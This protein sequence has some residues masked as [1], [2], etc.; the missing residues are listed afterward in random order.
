MDQDIIAIWASYTEQANELTNK[1]L[2][3][4]SI[5]FTRLAAL[6]GISIPYLGLPGLIASII[7]VLLSASWFALICSFK[8]L[9]KAKF[10]VISKIEENMD[11]K[12]YNDE[13]FE[14]KK[15][16]YLRITTCEKI[17][18]IIFVLG[19]VSLMIISI[20]KLYQIM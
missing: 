20:L 11:I 1:R 19:F 15:C 14:A 13:W 6:L 4:S 9:N 2:T 5:L 8:R 3:M 18:S 16:K 17:I 10:A 7:G 12:P